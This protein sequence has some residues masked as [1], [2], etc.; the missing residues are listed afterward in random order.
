MTSVASSSYQGPTGGHGV[1]V[2]SLPD[3]KQLHGL[4]GTVGVPDLDDAV[5]AGADEDPAVD[6]PA[7]TGQ[8]V[9]VVVTVTLPDVKVQ[10]ATADIVNIQSPISGTSGQVSSLLGVEVEGG[11]VGGVLAD[12]QTV[13]TG[14]TQSAHCPPSQLLA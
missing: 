13:V 8:A 3:H 4:T 10:R 11:E 14:Q 7:D 6:P 9:L 5:L 1:S 12:V 2:Q